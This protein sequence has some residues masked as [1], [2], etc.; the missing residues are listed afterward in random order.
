M[1]DCWLFR[2]SVAVRAA[3]MLA[4]TLAAAAS[5]RAEGPTTA[6]GTDSS[7]NPSRLYTRPCTKPVEL[8]GICSLKFNILLHHPPY[9][10]LAQ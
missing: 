2:R 5:D 3:R 4:A 1:L 6:A 8:L 9:V 7:L 10:H